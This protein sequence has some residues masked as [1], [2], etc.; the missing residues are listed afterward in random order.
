LNL[1]KLNTGDIAYMDEDGFYFI[2]GRLKRFIKIF[3]N[4]VNL[5][6]VEQILLARDIECACIGVDDKL[7]VYTTLENKSDE[8]L[9]LLTSKL[10]FN[11]RAFEIRII[12]QI[13]KNSSGKIL[14]SQLLEK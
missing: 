5:D 13:P 7:I 2:T 4:R 9:N 3:G 11:I 10:K 8:I 14:Y 6:E 1:G 12:S